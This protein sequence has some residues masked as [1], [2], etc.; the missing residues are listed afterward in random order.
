MNLIS[1]T[2]ARRISEDA[3][4]IKY[5]K[6]IKEIFQLIEIMAKEGNKSVLL[7]GQRYI[8]AIYHNEHLFQERSY[9]VTYY[10]YAKYNITPCYII[11][12]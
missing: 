6:E 1:A 3:N 5:K 10:S 7:S 9:K 12:W 8:E 4:I 11:S 2:E